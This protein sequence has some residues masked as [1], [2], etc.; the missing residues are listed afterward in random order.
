MKDPYAKF[1]AILNK[2]DKGIEGH[3][4]SL[5][6]LNNEFKKGKKWDIT[7]FRYYCEMGQYKL[8]QNKIDEAKQWF[9]QGIS[10][11]I[12]DIKI[13]KDI[14]DGV[15]TDLA[16]P[17]FGY[18][19][20]GLEMAIPCAQLPLAALEKRNVKDCTANC[21]KR[22]LL[23]LS[24]LVNDLEK[25]HKIGEDIRNTSKGTDIKAD[26]MPVSTGVTAFCN[27]YALATLDVI[28]S[29]LTK[30][31]AQFENGIDI[32]SRIK[33]PNI[34]KH[35]HPWEILDLEMTVLYDIALGIGMRPKIDTPFIPK[36]V[37]DNGYWNH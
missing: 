29:L 26:G 14:P 16:H 11:Y 8:L 6:Y 22:D 9:H 37:I 10:Y 30:S 18:L 20:G 1:R 35:S 2:V 23:I 12:R 17:Y 24:Y 36:A 3:T 33:I 34:K 31:T 32:W 15:R 4:L 7:H 21:H 19:G 5:N 13:F 27:V 25:K 28:E